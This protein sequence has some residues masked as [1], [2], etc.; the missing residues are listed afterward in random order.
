M[1]NVMLMQSQSVPSQSWAWQLT[2]TAVDVGAW[3]ALCAV[4]GVALSWLRTLDMP[5]ATGKLGH[6]EAAQ[7]TRRLARA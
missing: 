1:W 2:D 3:F 5:E 6:A 7:R 4:L